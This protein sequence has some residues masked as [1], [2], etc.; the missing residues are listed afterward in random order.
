MGIYEYEWSEGP[1][2]ILCSP[3]VP[4]SSPTRF[5][6]PSQPTLLIVS[7]T[8]APLFRAW[9]AW[10]QQPDPAEKVL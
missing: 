10:A 5:K 3:P 7:K 9:L 4:S 8:T 1:H 2:T 6:V